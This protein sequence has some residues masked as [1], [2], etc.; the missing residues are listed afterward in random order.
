MV[1]GR[2]LQL[3]HEKSLKHIQRQREDIGGGL[4]GKRGRNISAGQ[5]LPSAV[6]GPGGT[7][8]RGAGDRAGDREGA[9]EGLCP[10]AGQG[11]G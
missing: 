6:L 2:K 4:G 7:R 5:G 3:V 9:R 8:A 10:Q 11:A 1:W